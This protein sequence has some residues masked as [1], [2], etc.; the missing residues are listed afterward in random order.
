MIFAGREKKWTKGCSVTMHDTRC[1]AP[2]RYSIVRSEG[3]V[4]LLALLLLC[5]HS[6]GACSWRS[7]NVVAEYWDY[8]A[9]ERTCS[10][11]YN[12]IQG[13]VTCTSCSIQGQ[14]STASCPGPIGSG[15]ASY[16]CAVRCTSC[17]GCDTQAEAD[18]AYCALNPTAEGCVEE[19]VPPSCQAD[20]QQCV[21]LGGVWQKVASNSTQCASTCNLCG[22]AGQTRVLNSYNKI[23]CQKDKAPPDSAQRCTPPVIGSGWGME[24]SVFQSDDGLIDCGSITTADGEI[25]QENAARYKRFCMDHDEYEEQV[26][27]NDVGGSSSSGGGG[28]SSSED[29]GHSFGTELEALGGLYGVLDTIRDTLTKRLTPAT[30]EIRD[31]LYNFKLCTALEPLQIDWTGMP[32]DTSMLQIDTAILK[33][34]KPMMDSSVKLDSAQLKVLKQLDSLYKRG[35]VNDTD[36]VQAVNAIK[37]D[38][39]DV[40]S[41]VKGVRHGIDSLID[42]MRKYL[43]RSNQLMD[44]IAGIAAGGFGALGDSIGYLRGDL[45]GYMTAGSLEGDTGS[46]VYDGVGVDTGGYGWLSDIDRHL[47]Q[48]MSDSA[49]AGVFP[50]DSSMSSSSSQDT[51]Y[52]VPNEDSL[53]AVLRADVDSSRSALAD[54]FESAFDTLSKEFLLINFDSLILEPLGARVPNTN[55][56]PDHCFTFTIDGGSAQGQSWLGDVGTLDFGLCRPL[57][58]LNI[59]VFLLLRIIA[60]ILVAISCVYIGLWFIGGRKI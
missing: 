24:S 5:T 58:G 55:T 10:V 38:I 9:N 21:G 43:D 28:N 13:F 17:L 50:I 37:G 51:S 29:I 16:R 52:F 60:R 27:T 44:T 48:S 12:N 15:C 3:V 57:P 6:W 53:Y 19:D 46:N 23:C 14:Y 36:I 31:C 47:G 54:T 56:C 42:S 30:E 40:E 49:F 18:S 25:I 26:D 45:E 7:T 39:N 32:Q 33:H 34:I 1:V 22:S 35:L 20:Y 4:L 8:G 41:S 11:S 59:N 2:T